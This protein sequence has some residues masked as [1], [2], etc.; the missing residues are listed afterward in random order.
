[1]SDHSTR[2][3]LWS[4]QGMRRCAICGGKIYTST[5]PE[6]FSSLEHVSTHRGHYAHP[7]KP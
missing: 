7:A 3:A 5:D 6:G 4:S 2:L 1:M